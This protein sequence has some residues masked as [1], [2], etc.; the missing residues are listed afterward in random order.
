MV[1]KNM[2]NLNIMKKLLENDLKMVNYIVRVGRADFE[3]EGSTIFQFYKLWRKPSG[4][5]ESNGEP[6][7]YTF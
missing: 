7:L 1:I 4:Y 6:D 3:S 2:V 5:H